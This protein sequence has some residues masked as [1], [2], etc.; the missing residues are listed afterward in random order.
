MEQA[1]DFLHHVQHNTAKIELHLN[2]DKTEFMSFNQE[3]EAVL[4]SFNN[5][6]IKKEDNFKYSRPWIDNTENDV[7]VRIEPCSA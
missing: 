3:Q 2:A 6:N 5:E 4:K 1:Q 7:K